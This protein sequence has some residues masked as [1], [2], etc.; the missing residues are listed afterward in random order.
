MPSLQASGVGAEGMRPIAAITRGMMASTVHVLTGVLLFAIERK[1]VPEG[2]VGRSKI[3]LV[4]F[5]APIV[6]SDFRRLGRSVDAVATRSEADAVRVI[7]ASSKVE[8]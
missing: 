3:P 6:L 2:T 5:K 8:G 4:P 1:S 7:L